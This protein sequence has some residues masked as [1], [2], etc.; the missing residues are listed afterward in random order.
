MFQTN[1]NIDVEE[2]R[3]IDGYSLVNI[4]GIPIS[5]CLEHCVQNCLCM[6]FDMCNNDKCYLRSSNRKLSK[7]I[8]LNGCRHCEC[9]E[10]C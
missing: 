10:V 9:H 1:F 8:V 4:S 6:S 5:Q 2:N 3:A 7:V